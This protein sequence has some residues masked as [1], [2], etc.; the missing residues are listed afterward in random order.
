MDDILEI[1]NE[2]LSWEKTRRHAP[3]PWN[4]NNSSALNG[5]GRP[6]QPPV[7]PAHSGTHSNVPP[8]PKPPPPRVPPGKGLGDYARGREQ[9]VAETPRPNP[10]VS[11]HAMYARPS[12]G[13]P[14]HRAQVVHTSEFEGSGAIPDFPGSGYSFTTTYTEGMDRFPAASQFLLSGINR[15]GDVSYARPPPQPFQSNPA[16][17]GRENHP[18]ADGPYDDRRNGRNSRE[19]DYEEEPDHSRHSNIDEHTNNDTSERNSHTR[20]YSDPRYL[21]DGSLVQTRRNSGDS[22][23]EP[24]VT[25]HASSAHQQP[26]GRRSDVRSD[27]VRSHNDNMPSHTTTRSSATAY[28]DSPIQTSGPVPFALPRADQSRAN[29]V[30][31]DL[32]L[33]PRARSPSFTSDISFEDNPRD[34]TEIMPAKDP[35]S[36]L[37]PALRAAK[38]REKEL[39]SVTNR[40]KNTRLAKLQLERDDLEKKLEKATQDLAD[41][42]LKA[43][44]KMK[45][46]SQLFND[47]KKDLDNYKTISNLVESDFRKTHSIMPELQDLRRQIKD[48]LD[49]ISPYIETGENS[50]TEQK[51][52]TKI[53]L[54]ELKNAKEMVDH[55]YMEAKS[56]IGLL[57]DEMAHDKCMLASM[58]ESFQNLIRLQGEDNG[59]VQE[60]KALREKII[61]HD[62]EVRKKQEQKII[63]TLLKGAEL[64]LTNK[65]LEE[66]IETL[67]ALQKIAE[68]DL[69]LVITRQETKL[70]E[71]Q[72]QLLRNEFQIKEGQR[73]LEQSAERWKEEF[74][75]IR[76]SERRE[77]QGKNDAILDKERR[78]L[79]L[80]S[81]IRSYEETSQQVKLQLSEQSITRNTSN[82]CLY[83]YTRLQDEIASLTERRKTSEAAKQKAE[84]LLQAMSDQF[85]LRDAGAIADEDLSNR[86]AM[87]L[88][89]VVQDLTH[90]LDVAHNKLDELQ[91]Q[92]D[93]QRS[94]EA[95]KLAEVENE[96]SH[97]R[98]ELQ[99]QKT[100]YQT[101][102][103]ERMDACEKQ[104]DE[105]LRRSTTMRERYWT[106]DLTS[107]EMEFVEV[108]KDD[109]EK[110]HELEGTRTR[111]AIKKLQSE[112]EK[113]IVKIADLERSLKI[114]MAKA[115]ESLPLTRAG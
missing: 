66:E 90:K 79:Q 109:I 48:S 81:E 24:H 43:N 58:E 49:V 89:L 68:D 73:E 35:L 39:R 96:L 5:G 83:R 7:R 111:N 95:I 25:Q 10:P 53:L 40:D 27:P 64:E 51:L 105:L 100:E 115:R 61:E 34:L 37:I 23:R 86:R 91:K 106:K 114:E 104:R 26:A 67:R 46:G 15:S 14:T 98:E 103:A 70:L 6:L 32:P 80:E 92:L 65:N 110:A 84:E 56:T 72:Q 18:K 85:D 76:A 31:S 62:L 41:T 97:R 45:R 8:A 55:D 20:D 108:I 59:A 33:S 60:V 3:V 112:N 11:N 52:K 29:P 47:M 75:V 113:H 22:T 1:D 21:R 77:R 54:A 71:Q 4:P 102:Y 74:K 2:D 78:V 9:R 36:Y 28:P 82:I 63:D 101:N 16:T 69:K 38:R 12:P 44:E 93:K 30:P 99:Q 57:R 17:S 94:E 50:L 107:A 87:E 88:Q 13:S 42:K 19:A